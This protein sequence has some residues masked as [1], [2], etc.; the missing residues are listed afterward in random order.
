M[1]S[2]ETTLLEIVS[3]QP[4][5]I[6]AWDLLLTCVSDIESVNTDQTFQIIS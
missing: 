2:A 4:A 3:I 5:F 6:E 1:K